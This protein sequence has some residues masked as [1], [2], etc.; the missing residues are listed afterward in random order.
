MWRL[1][2]RVTWIENEVNQFSAMDAE[3]GKLLIYRQ[4]CQNPKYKKGWGISSANEFGR[5]ASGVSSR[6]KCTNT[7]KFV[8]KHEVPHKRM[9]GVTYGQFVCMVHPEKAEK[10]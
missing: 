9:K 4:L 8:H 2:Q 7:I 6:I 3:T 1:M 5:L 10:N